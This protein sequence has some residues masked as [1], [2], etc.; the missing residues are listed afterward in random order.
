V[1]IE[2]N[3]YHYDPGDRLGP[4]VDLDAKLVTHILYFNEPWNDQWGGELAV[5]GSE[6]P[7]DVHAL[8]APRLGASALVVRSERSWHAV[9]PVTGEVRRRSVTVTFYRPG[10]PSTMWPLDDLQP[11]TRLGGA[12]DWS[13]GDHS[14]PGERRRVGGAHRG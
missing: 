14:H 2:V 4:H 8:V 6:D 5:L 9:R 7:S 12:A 1:P 3:A 13:D 10:S 11:L